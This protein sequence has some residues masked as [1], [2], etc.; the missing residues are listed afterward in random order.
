M[1]SNEACLSITVNG[2]VGQTGIATKTSP[3][4]ISIQTETT[5]KLPYPDEKTHFHKGSNNIEKMNE[6]DLTIQYYINIWV[7]M[8]YYCDYF[9]LLVH[10]VAISH[11]A[12]LFHKNINVKNESNF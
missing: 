3:A 10:Y 7:Q 4:C 8:Q 9:S 2:T 12:G 1:C 6:R 5:T 11:S